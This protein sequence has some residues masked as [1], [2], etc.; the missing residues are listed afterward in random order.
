MKL[1]IT[2]KVIEHTEFKF[3]IGDIIRINTDKYSNQTGIIVSIDQEKD[4]YYTYIFNYF[5]VESFKGTDIDTMIVH[6]I[7]LTDP[8]DIIRYKIKYDIVT[9]E[10]A[11]Q[12]LPAMKKETT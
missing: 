5:K 6:H 1:V 8:F 2:K 7:P 9:M 3:D 11:I 10:P 4:L 12:L